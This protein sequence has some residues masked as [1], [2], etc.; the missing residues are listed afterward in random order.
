MYISFL[1]DYTNNNSGN[2]QF[3]LKRHKE[4]YDKYSNAIK[5]LISNNGILFQPCKED[6]YFDIYTTLYYLSLDVNNHRNI[7][8]W[9]NE[10]I[11]RINYNFVY[12]YKYPS[13]LSSYNELIRH[14]SE[15]TEEYRRKITI[16]S[17]LYPLLAAFSAILGFDD[18][19]T[20]I[21]VF[22]KEHLKHCTFQI[23][24]PDEITEQ[25]IYTGSDIPGAMLVRPCIENGKDRYLEQIF[26]ECEKNTYFDELS[27]MQ[28]GYWPLIFLAGRHYRRCPIPYHFI[29]GLASELPSPQ[30]SDT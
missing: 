1:L 27:A 6:Q 16:S 11:Y 2:V 5:Q 21:Q 14:P 26:D 28:Y 30:A 18:L 7:H 25:N 12:H 4:T 10:M 23:W 20:K 3:H 24:Y 9:L 17:V 15:K 13:I 19:F 29:K 8:K 22:K